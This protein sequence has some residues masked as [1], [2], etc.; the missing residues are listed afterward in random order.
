MASLV[1]LLALLPAEHAR[2]EALVAVLRAT[3]CA[4]LPHQTPAGLWQTA[5]LN[6]P[7]RA[8][9]ETSGSALCAY[10]LMK[11]ARLGVLPDDHAIAGARALHA[12]SRA[13]DLDAPDGAALRGVSGPT[14]PYPL[15]GY[16]LVPRVRHAPWGTAA[17]VLAALEH[18]LY[19]PCRDCI[20][21][22]ATLSVSPR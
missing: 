16:A 22:G 7:D 15:L 21:P 11:G 19:A 13:V 3:A 20:T 17:F 6:R 12:A 4:I 10:G 14:M 9:A 1:D 8:Y 2:R 18:E 5:A